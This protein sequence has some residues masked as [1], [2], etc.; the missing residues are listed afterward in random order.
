MKKQE[1]LAKKNAD[2]VKS[3]EEVYTFLQENYE[4]EGQI[5]KYKS[6][7]TEPQQQLLRFDGWTVIQKDNGADKW[8]YSSWI[9]I[10]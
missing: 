7:L 6:S 3:M 5:L 4:Y 1:I 8:G 10:S 2:L 9:E